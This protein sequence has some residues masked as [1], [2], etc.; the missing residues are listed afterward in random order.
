MNHLA[1]IAN[2][3]EEN[4]LG[5]IQ[6]D[7]AL[8][9]LAMVRVLRPKTIVEFG[10]SYGKSAFNFLQALDGKGDVY[11][12]DIAPSSAEYAA[13]HFSSFANFHFLQKSQEH[14]LPSDTDGKLVDFAFFDGAH[15]AVFV[16]AG[17]AAGTELDKTDKPIILV[18]SFA[19]NSMTLPGGRS[20]LADVP[21]PVSRGFFDRFCQELDRGQLS[22]LRQHA[23]QAKASEV[24]DLRTLRVL[25]VDDVAVN[26]EVLGE[27][28]RPMFSKAPSA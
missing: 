24:P 25:A 5:P 1:H 22:S 17:D 8:L 9:L 20:P 21:M 12:Y 11:S 16:R 4:A 23:E 14:F 18:R 28:L 13:K 6:R 26:R 3:A 2:Y 15:D 10:F 19:A 7:E 27:A